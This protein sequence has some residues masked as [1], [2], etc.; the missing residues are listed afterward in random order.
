MAIAES[1]QFVFVAQSLDN[2]LPDTIS[3][4]GKIVPSVELRSRERVLV[5]KST[6]KVSSL[7][8]K[9]G[10]NGMPVRAFFI[11]DTRD[12]LL[13]L[14]T[15]SNDVAGRVAPILCLC[16][17]PGRRDEAWLRSLHEAVRAFSQ[18]IRRRINPREISA[19][20]DILSKIYDD[21]RIH[22]RAKRSVVNKLSSA[23]D[24]LGS[25][26]RSLGS[27]NGNFFAVSPGYFDPEDLDYRTADPEL[28]IIAPRNRRVI[29]VIS[30]AQV[31]VYYSDRRLRRLF[32]ED[33]FSIVEEPASP[34]RAGTLGRW[35][36]DREM[37]VAGNVLI[38]N[39][40]KLDSYF[41][42]SV[43]EG[44]ILRAKNHAFLM[45]CQIL[46]ASSVDIQS[47]VGRS[48]E[49]SN[50]L[51]GK[52]QADS[53]VGLAEK[54]RTQIVKLTRQLEN[55][56]RLDPQQPNILAARQ[57]I[58]DCGLHEQVFDDL[59][60]AVEQGTLRS[61]EIYVDAHDELSNLETRLA[62]IE[63]SRGGLDLRDKRRESSES[64]I[65]FKC[66]VT[67]DRS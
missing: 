53:L 59:I 39:P 22:K 33:E 51:R 13:E 9:Y 4:N 1:E 62:K 6:T 29:L 12:L 25:N 52:F 55:H 27:D 20:G 65:S 64:H 42:A 43:A 35:L 61:Q 18:V 19:I 47:M 41:D 57:F 60:E 56:A 66:T 10:L 14:K 17:L 26:L 21:D 45:L 11:T 38:Q 37:M 58:N 2:S 16:K 7:G 24:S 49:D 44:E 3:I 30:Q 50:E 28:E 63:G 40:Y 48:I 8:K 46:G 15:E 5:I 34:P 67:F 32:L 36:F 31:R 23:R 54:T